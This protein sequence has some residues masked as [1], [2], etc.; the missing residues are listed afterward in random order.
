MQ[1]LISQEYLFNK[2]R[3]DS[4]VDFDK[5]V[6]LIED[7]QFLKIKPLL[8]N[9]LYQEILT[10]STPVT[11]LTAANQLLLDDYILPC[12]V[13]YFMS[14]AVIP[15]KFNYT[16]IGITSKNS[17]NSQQIETADISKLV[18]YWKNK[19][20]EYGTLMQNYIRA[21]LD[22]YPEFLTNVGLDQKKPDQN[23]YNLD[24]YLPDLYNDYLER[25]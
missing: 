11:S 14:D 17:D 13:R 6:P 15:F 3:I 10:Q 2:T 20:D 22:D 7:V 23:S 25:I 12:M 16:N 9:N 4:N 8:G 21:N 24:I 18:D 5:L 19:A 1:L